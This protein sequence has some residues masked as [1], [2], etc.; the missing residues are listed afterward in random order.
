MVLLHVVY[1]TVCVWVGANL[2][3]PLLSVCGL[4]GC[5]SWPDV[6]KGN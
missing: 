1:H 5:I 6:V 3:C 2:Y 4:W